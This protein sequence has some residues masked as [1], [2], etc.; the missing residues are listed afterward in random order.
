MALLA[1]WTNYLFIVVEVVGLS[2]SLIFLFLLL[3]F[4]EKFISF[5]V[6]FADDQCSEVVFKD[7]AW[8]LIDIVS[9]IFPFWERVCAPPVYFTS[10]LTTS[11]IIPTKTNQNKP[12]KSY[13]PSLGNFFTT[14]S[15]HNQHLVHSLWQIILLFLPEKSTN[16]TLGLGWNDCNFTDN[17][18][19]QVSNLHRVH[20]L[21]SF[22]LGDGSIELTKIL[23]I[24]KKKFL[25][26]REVQ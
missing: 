19:L 15:N 1:S 26:F 18:S 3:N 13:S 22:L 20:K 25:L 8:Q 23:E 21:N 4:S 7:V 2:Q 16:L 17:V 10:N 11:C 14:L 24:W 9:V 5:S 12:L 6:K